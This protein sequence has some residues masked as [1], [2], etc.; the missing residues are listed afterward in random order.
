M[1]FVAETVIRRKWWVLTA[2]LALAVLGVIAA[3]RAIDNLSQ[4]FDLPGQPAF[5][6]NQRVVAQFG[7]GG[8]NAPVLLELHSAE[9]RVP[10]SAGTATAD[11][12]SKAAPGARIASFADHSALQSKDGATAVVLVYPRAA[13][14]PTQPYPQALPKLRAAAT[15]LTKQLNSTSAVTVRVTGID[16]AKDSSSGGGTSIL[17]ETLFGALGALVVLTIVFGSFLALTPLIVAGSSILTTFLI[18]WGISATTQVSSVVEFLLALIGLGVAID[19][20]LLLVTR[21]REELGQGHSPDEAIGR[22][23][24]TAGRSVLFSGITVAVS[25]AALI[26]LPVPFLRSIGFTGLLIPLIS[27]A[28]A[29]TLLPAMLSLAGRRLAWPHRRSTNPE[30]RLWRGVGG[31][32]VRHRWLSVIASAA[33]MLAL[34]APVLGIR[35]GTAANNS[36]ASRG[37][38]A[39]SALTQLQESGIGDGLTQPV[40]IL[41]RDP[42]ATTR[43]LARSHDVA[44]VIA[45]SA[46]KQGST[47]VV[48]AWTTS[49]SSTPAGSDAATRI[50]DIAENAGA[51]VGGTPAQNTDYI[52]AVYGNTWWIAP[53]IA[54]VTFALL[55]LALR[56]WVLPIK[57]LVLNVVSLSAALGMTTIIWQHGFLTSALFGQK[58]TG[59]ITVWVPVAVFAFL[60]GLSMD[61]EVF[62]LTRIKEEHDTGH[63]TDDATVHG[64]ARTGR[65]VTS[66]ALILFLAFISLSRIDD[67]DVKIFAT[68]LALGIAV[69]ATI[70]RGILAPALVAALGKINWNF[71]HRWVKTTA[72]EPAAKQQTATQ[73]TA[74]Q[75]T[76]SGP[77][78]HY[79]I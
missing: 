38:P 20:A 21:W 50:R 4:S 22:A 73:Q 67:T 53:I 31:F 60:F 29:L 43:Q 11:A 66:A 1:N 9:G 47:A 2:W 33:V 28:A 27:V 72:S 56:S 59:A 34:A 41:T 18:L 8:N 76:L 12:A 16:A 55:A 44:G 37:G 69:D 52:S 78:G 42:A 5:E 74:T 63:S 26:A 57:A 49:D 35:L 46:W 14:N 36:L 48:D 24:A 23:V 45:P 15:Q 71:P 64:V 51:Y 61:Y 3:P 58:S 7:S 77:A 13:P 75:Q 32:V 19:Y 6:V 39:G 40:E 30:S 79:R 54:V 68:A 10:A 17:A 70:V 65:L 62:L 25:L